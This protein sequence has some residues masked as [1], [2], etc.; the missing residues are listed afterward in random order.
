MHCPNCKNEFIKI[1]LENVEIDY[2]IFCKG[3]WLD[4]GELEMLGSYV[5]Y[6]YYKKLSFIEKII[7]EKNKRCPVCKCIM[8]KTALYDLPEILL[9][10]C[11]KHGLWFDKGELQS[12]LE[13]YIGENKLVNILKKIN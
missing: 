4:N 9:D 3:I 8:N 12:V 11:P 10:K 6:K 7:K 1:E 13:S 2:C 5:N